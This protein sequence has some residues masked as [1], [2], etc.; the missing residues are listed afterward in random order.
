MSAPQVFGWCPGAL[1]PMMSG[2]GLVVRLRVPMGRLSPEQIRHVATLARTY[3]NGM[4]DLSARANLQLRGVTTDSHA[5]LIDGLREIG[6]VDA[7]LAAEARRNITVT[8]FWQDG[9]DSQRVAQTLARA[10]SNHGAPDLP[11]KFGFA[12]DCGERPVLT[13]TSA[14]IRV[15][16]SAAG[17]ICRADG[18]GMGQPVTVDTAADAALA[19]ARWFLDT[20]GVT[21]GRG[22]MAAHIATQG[23]PEAADTPPLPAVAPPEPSVTAHGTLLGFAFGQT[24]AESFAQLAELGALR[25]TPWRMVLIEGAAITEPLPDFITDARDPRRRVQVC[26][27]A[28]G[29]RQA[30]SDTRDAARAIAAHLSPDSDDTIHIS[31]CAKGCAHPAPAPVTLTASHD[32][33][34]TLI[35]HGRAGDP[36]QSAPLTVTQIQDRRL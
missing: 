32:G 34:F 31:G 28:P 33:H 9:D 24:T 5:A 25:L 3:G 23:A 2:D 16:H 12:I 14:D 7:D 8:P 17:L 4:I 27:G 1:R 18:A 15:E 29:C 10:L 13:R 30:L 6:L 26:T 20:G 35:R 22:R 21:D 11:S 19:L 36:P